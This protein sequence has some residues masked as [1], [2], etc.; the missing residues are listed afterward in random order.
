MTPPTAGTQMDLFTRSTKTIVA[1]AHIGAL[2]GSPLYDSDGGMQKRTDAYLTDRFGTGLDSFTV[3]DE[4]FDAP[5]FEAVP[6]RA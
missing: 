3:P 6:C 4:A 1:M 2:P 5:T